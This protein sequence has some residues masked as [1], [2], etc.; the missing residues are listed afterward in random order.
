MIY[1]LIA[2]LCGSLFSVVFKLCQQ[3]GIDTFQA[4]LFNYVT[5]FLVTWLPVLWSWIRGGNA[6]VNPFS[7]RWLWMAA[8]QGFFFCFGFALMSH[9]TRLNGVALTNA[10]ARASLVL[11]VVA[12]WLLLSQPA[13]AWFPVMLVIVALLMIVVQPSGSKGALGRA[14]LFLVLVF[15]FYGVSDFSLKL[16][17]HA[18][19]TQHAGDESLIARNLSA[20]TGCIFFFAMCYSLITVVWKNRT[21]LRLR[22]KN[23]DTRP[24][25]QTSA[26]TP[27][28]TSWREV[29]AGA[30]LGVANMACTW[31]MLRGLN[32]LPTGIYYPLYNIGI[33]IV[34]TLFGVLLFRERLQP[35]QYVGL[36]LAML[37]IA[38]LSR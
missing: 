7:E 33:V 22:R 10:A 16:V 18:V 12:S 36:A 37:A 20:L 15:F 8:I 13:P 11:P 4:I 30:V 26:N 17:Q 5:A 23:P 2:I 38:I 21:A 9:S 35:L 14:W 31:C 3:R 34:G 27:I 1:L 19:S 6:P 32:V 24:E 28:S 25:K 29:G